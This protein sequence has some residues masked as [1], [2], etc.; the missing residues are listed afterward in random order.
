M[1]GGGG[2]RRF[3]GAQG[4]KFRAAMRKCGINFRGGRERFFS[5]PAGKRALNSFV[6]CVRKNG[7]NLPA[8]NTSGNGPVFDPS[9]INRNDPKLIVGAAKCRH[10][11]PRPRF[12]P[13]RG[14]GPP[15]GA[16]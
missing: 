15:G 2:N 8:P 12:G 5:S 1:L 11:L 9:K 13:G 6:D 4:A 10:L 16:Q 3:G 7:Y 14:G